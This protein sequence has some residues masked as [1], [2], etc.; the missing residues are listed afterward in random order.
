MHEGISACG[1]TEAIIASRGGAAKALKEETPQDNAD[2][3]RSLEESVCD[4]GVVVDSSDD[5][6]AVVSPPHPS[7]AAP[8]VDV[9]EHR[10]DSGHTLQTTTDGD[11]QHARNDF[12]M[13]LRRSY[14]KNTKTFIVSLVMFALGSVML[15]LGLWCLATC[16]P[17]TGGVIFVIIGVLS[18]LPG[19]YA[20]LVFVQHAR[21]IE[22]YD[23]SDLPQGF[24][25]V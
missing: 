4:F 11:P 25:K 24:D 21:Q 6:P 19:A 2:A 22:G 10:R 17:K 9:A 3:H 16:D 14:V 8:T 5:A 12:L 20:L 18:F 13:R 15:G 7:G 1:S 23:P